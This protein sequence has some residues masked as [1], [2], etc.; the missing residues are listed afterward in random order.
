M[1]DEPDVRTLKS[2][3]QIQDLIASYMWSFDL[4]D[5]KMFR[6]IWHIDGVYDWGK[7]FGTFEGIHAICAFF[8]N[9][10]ATLRE[11]H[12]LSTDML[13]NIDGNRAEGIYHS[14]ARGILTDGT[15]QE[16]V[17]RYRATWEMRDGHWGYTRIEVE[18]FPPPGQDSSGPAVVGE[19]E[20]AQ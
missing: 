15:H 3:V 1:T 10:M 14:Y 11:A 6:S 5:S 18:T 2:R 16:V 8:E 17:G 19:G 20:A 12:H 4:H 7:A 9:S 13:I